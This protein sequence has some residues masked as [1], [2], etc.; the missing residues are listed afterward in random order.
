MHGGDGCPPDVFRPQDDLA[1]SFEQFRERFGALGAVS[2]DQLT[3][4][5]QHRDDPSQKVGVGLVADRH[6]LRGAWGALCVT[7]RAPMPLAGGVAAV[8]VSAAALPTAAARRW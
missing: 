5:Q 3:L 2:K 6:V 8:C 4:L 1:M 7:N